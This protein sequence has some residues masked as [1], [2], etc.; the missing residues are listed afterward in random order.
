MT[1]SF[2][3]REIPAGEAGDQGGAV[4]ILPEVASTDAEFTTDHGERVSIAER[5]RGVV[6]T[7]L[8]AG[9]YETAWRN[10]LIA[11]QQALD[12]FSTRGLADHHLSSPQF[13]HLAVYSGDGSQVL[14]LV[15]VSTLN[16]RVGPITG[17]VLDPEGNPQAQPAPVS[18][19]DESMRYY[20]QAQL[21]D[22]IF[23]SFRSL[24]LALENLLDSLEPQ[25]RGERE[26]EW[27]KRAL[28]KADSA[29]ELK[30]FLPKGSASN[31]VDAAYTYFYVETRTHL[32]HAKASRKPL[33]PYEQHGTN[34]L[35]SRHRQLT[36]LYLE[37]LEHVIGVRRPSGM[38]VKGGF[39]RMM[40]GLEAEPAIQITDDPGP[41]DPDAR[42][43]NPEGGSVAEA[44]ALREESLEVPFLRVFLARFTG[45]ELAAIQH[46]R[47]VGFLRVFLARLT[48][49]ELAAIQHLRK[50]ALT[51]KGELV[52][53]HIVEGDL[54]ISDLGSLEVQMGIRVR[55][56]GLPK[57]FAEM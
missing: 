43:I 41:E 34:L 1:I 44:P 38:L 51:S 27:L 16:V 26:K 33:L 36:S 42:S 19:W 18:V 11:A 50:T 31:P 48:G 13:E 39:E 32:F 24:W 5:S 20:R 28:A 56:A 57:S 21:S 45:A 22:D 54:K 8:T 35:V 46:P 15:G 29:I 25:A 6:V 49:A 2:D 3:N 37:L 53:G 12:I 40:T 47:K 23:E 7:E 55:N 30:R 10:G 4:F 17:E 52:S 14:R 9:D